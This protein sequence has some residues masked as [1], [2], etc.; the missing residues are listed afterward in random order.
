M[1]GKQLQFL[2]DSCKFLTEYIT[3]AQNLYYAFKFS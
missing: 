3:D 2:D 1:N